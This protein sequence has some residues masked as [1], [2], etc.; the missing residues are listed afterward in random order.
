M[1]PGYNSALKA[2][3][4]RHRHQCLLRKRRQALA[5]Q[6]LYISSGPILRTLKPAVRKKLARERAA[7]LWTLPSDADFRRVHRGDYPKHSLLR[8]PAELRQKIFLL[9]FDVRQM[10]Q[11]KFEMSGE[12]P[13]EKPRARKPRTVFERPP[14]G[15]EQ[16]ILEGINDRVAEPC[17]VASIASDDIRYVSQ[18]WQN[19][20]RALMHKKIDVDALKLPEFTLYLTSMFSGQREKNIVIRG[21]D[22]PLKGRRPG[23]CWYCTERHVPGKS[24]C[25]RA[26][27]DP[28]RWLQGT[29]PVG[30][31]RSRAQAKTSFQV[32]KVVFS[33]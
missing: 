3:A 25:S 29:R 4:G 7:S 9:S 30:G 1:Y 33:D 18:Q 32:K 15:L 12:K 28:Q 2:R 13:R 10:A 19:A 20:I 5:K 8:L 6:K 26:T 23:K 31:W 24:D 17:Q 11:R 21:D 27:G 16:I 14:P 22:R